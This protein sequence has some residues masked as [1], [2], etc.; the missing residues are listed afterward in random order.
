MRSWC[1]WHCLTIALKH[2]IFN[3]D[4]NG[5]GQAVCSCAPLSGSDFLRVAYWNC[6]FSGSILRCEYDDDSNRFV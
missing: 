6:D 2:A 5:D 4:A 3:F 1:V